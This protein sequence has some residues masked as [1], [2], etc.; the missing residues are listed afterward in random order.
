MAWPW[1]AFLST[2]YLAGLLLALRRPRTEA[3]YEWWVEGLLFLPAL[4]EL[5]GQLAAIYEKI[6]SA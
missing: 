1:R 2:A 4:V 5:P 6:T 3:F